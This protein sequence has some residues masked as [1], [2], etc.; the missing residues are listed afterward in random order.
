MN[1]EFIHQRIC[2]FSGKDIDPNID[3]QVVTILRDKFNIFLPQRPTLD[4]SL[5]VSGSDHE[6]ISLLLKYRTEY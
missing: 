2:V 1:K 6:I 4:Q 5:A 3:E